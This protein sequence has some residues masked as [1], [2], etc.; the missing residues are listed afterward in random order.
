MASDVS[1][2]ELIR[3]V[4]AGDQAA[5]A[6]LVRE[7]EPEVRRYVRLR[8]TAPGLR[9]FL[10]SVDI[11]QSVLANFFVR[12]AAG[13][14][15]LEEPNDLIR[16]LVRMAYNKVVDYARRPSSRRDRDGG[17]GL[18]SNLSAGGQNPSEVVADEELLRAVRCRLTDEERVLVEERSAGLGW[19]EIAAARGGTPDAWRKKLERA[20]DRVCRDLGVDRESHA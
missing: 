4:R 3:R 12:V 16:L 13:Q 6:D 20:I 15:D 14:F 19:Q 2:C 8:L 5:A 17:S 1:F 9:R 11:C 7:Y 10:D 18:W